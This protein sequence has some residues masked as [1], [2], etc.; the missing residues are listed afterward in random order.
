MITCCEGERDERSLRDEA[1]SFWSRFAPELPPDLL[2]K[3]AREYGAYRQ[4]T[5]SMRKTERE[6]ARRTRHRESSAGGVFTPEIDKGFARVFGTLDSGP[7]G[8]S[9][10][11]RARR[12]WSRHTIA[13]RG[14]AVKKGGSVSV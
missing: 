9:A 1:D 12:F 4:V 6:I 5:A 11:P 3:I 10:T 7:I 2:T 8:K 13:K 14:P